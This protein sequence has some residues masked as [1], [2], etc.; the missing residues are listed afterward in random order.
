MADP[1]N[2]EEVRLMPVEDMGDEHKAFLKEH[3]ADLN[4]DEKAAFQEFLAVPAKE[5]EEE[6]HEG[7]T[8]E[9][10]TAREAK[11]A[12]EAGGVTETPPVFKTKE[13]ADA[14]VE[15]KIKEHDEAV[16][17]QKKEEEEAAKAPP[18]LKF[19]DPEWKPKNWN[20]FAV[21]FFKALVS[22]PELAKTITPIV[23]EELANM[24]VSERREIEKINEG[25]N[26]EMQEMFKE[27]LIPDP[28]S[29]EGIKIDK[30][31]SLI[32][33]QM[34]ANNM[35][36]A[37]DRW[38]KTPLEF[39]GGYDPGAKRVVSHKQKAGL[40]SKGGGSGTPA[41]KEKS[42]K[43]VHGKSLDTLLEEET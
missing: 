20:D 37:Y 29:P 41:K 38:A 2:L 16:A 12:A 13:E 42:Y 40:V 32:G 24:S 7:E 33:A 36:E 15:D 10:K 31:I 23:R 8:E 25:F 26:T 14:W 43:D 30:Q 22:K 39:G 17:A 4:D 28:T 9:D 21:Q 6:E 18:E 19:F 1:L 27:G 3:E 35:R 11:E 34:K 5:D